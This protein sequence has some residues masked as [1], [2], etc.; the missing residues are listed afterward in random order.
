MIFGKKKKS[1][2][3]DVPKCENA[4]DKLQKT[5]NESKL[6]LK[7]LIWVYGQ[8]G[9]N[10]GATLEGKAFNLEEVQKEYYTK[11]R[12]GIALQVQGLQIQTWTDAIEES[13]DDQTKS[14][15]TPSDGSKS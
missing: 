11:P 7:E 12:L 5:F 9:Y 13:R 3:V 8:L 15:T 14:G 4:L 6:S 1:T 2:V 10:I